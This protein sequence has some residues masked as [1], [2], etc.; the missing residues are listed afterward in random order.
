VIDDSL[1][2]GDTLSANDFRVYLANGG[3]LLFTGQEALGDYYHA[4]FGYGP[5]DALQP[6]MRGSSNAPLADGVFPAMPPQPSVV[7]VEEFN[8]FLKGMAFDL[9]T[10]GDGAGNQ[11]AV[12]EVQ[13]ADS[14]D[15]DTAPLFEVVNTIP[16]VENGYVGTRS[17]FEPTIERVKDPI[18]VPQEPVAWR[19]AELNFGLEGV[20]NSE[21]FN[22][23]QDLLQAI[24]DWQD[25]VVQVE[26][27]SASYF[28]GAPFSF[29]DFT[30]SMTSSKEADALYYRWDFGDGSGIQVTTDPFISH[31]Y[32]KYGFYQAY[33][34]VTDTFSH[35]AV[36]VP[37][38]VQVGY[39]IRFPI[40]FR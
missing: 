21:D 30:A 25:D 24:F 12:D 9:S 7:G 36:S 26:F 32:Q 13:W 23:R 17:S 4:F 2:F 18:G 11:Y 15:L 40:I 19:V 6:Y 35:K 20:N 14:V 8:S 16:T 33:V 1:Y 22:T 3:K 39:F 5:I 38:V 27:D 28:T 10:E 31:Q 37:V 29:V 34:E